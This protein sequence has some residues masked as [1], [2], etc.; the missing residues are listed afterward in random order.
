MKCCCLK[1]K[2]TLKE[3][4]NVVQN[5]FVDKQFKWMGVYFC[6]L[7]EVIQLIIFSEILVASCLYFMT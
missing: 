2:C 5:S 1:E 6:E 7:P 4:F 3:M